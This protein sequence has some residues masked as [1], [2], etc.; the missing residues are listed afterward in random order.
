MEKYK[1]IPKGYM[2]V[3][4]IAKKMNI[5]VRTLQYYDKEG[6]LSPSG[7]SEGGRRLYTNKDIVKLHQILSLKSLGFSLEDIKN[8]L[9]SLDSPTQ[10]AKA[11]SDQADVM[12]EKVAELTDAIHAIEA[13]KAEVVQMQTVDFEKYA[14]I[15][16]NFGMKNE[17]YWIIKHI[18]NSTM[19]MLRNRFAERDDAALMIKK[20]NRLLNKAVQ[21]NNKGINP[22]S[23]EAVKLAKEFWDTTMKCIGGDASLL[24]QLSEIV[25]NANLDNNKARE[26]Q[27]VANSFLEPALTAYFIKSGINPF[28]STEDKNK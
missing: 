27:E 8:R 2:T 25:Q 26:K 19:D 1:A 18:D 6:V 14:D 11:L 15:V 12:R 20:I 7:T 10:V 23:D 17:F 24:P 16:R 3:G 21:Y 9:I 5:T 28:E 22:E 4:E 13:L